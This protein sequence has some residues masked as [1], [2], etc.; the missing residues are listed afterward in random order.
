MKNRAY[1]TLKNASNHVLT[2][3]M[4]RLGFTRPQ[5]PSR[6][7]RKNKLVSIRQAKTLLQMASA[8]KGYSY[9]IVNASCQCINNRLANEKK[10]IKRNFLFTFSKHYF[11]L[12]YK[13]GKLLQRYNYFSNKK[14]PGIQYLCFLSVI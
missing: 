4:S 8:L 10:N 13:I 2:K 9:S 3:V 6:P 11:S 5:V 12:F 14:T 7:T 1:T